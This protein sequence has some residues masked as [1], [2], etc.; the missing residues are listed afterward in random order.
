MVNGQAVPGLPVRWVND[1]EIND[2]IRLTLGAR[3]RA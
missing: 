1:L 2:R 3:L